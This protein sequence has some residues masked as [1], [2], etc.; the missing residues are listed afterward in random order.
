MD[1]G[2]PAV[3]DTAHIERRFTTA[4][5]DQFAELT[6]DRNQVHL[7]DDAARAMGFDGRIVHGALVAAL[8]S[9]ILGTIL[10]GKGTIYLGQEVRFRRP[11]YPDEL[12][13]ASVEVTSV[14]GDKPIVELRTW[15]ETAG[16][17]AIEGHAVVLVRRPR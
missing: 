14:R 12:V 16:E 5:I 11:V 6:G 17:V 2:L 4:E 13:R 10:P 15:A 1:D 8:L 3:G 9:R 7:D